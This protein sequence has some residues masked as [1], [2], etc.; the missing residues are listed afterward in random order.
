M[1]P[2]QKGPITYKDNSPQKALRP[3]SSSSSR[4]RD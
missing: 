2:R 4:D 3:T 1:V